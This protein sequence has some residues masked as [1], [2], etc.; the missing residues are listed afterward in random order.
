MLSGWEWIVIALAIVAILV[1]GP[2][3]IPELAKG[4]GRARGE[5]E[6]ASREYSVGTSKSEK[7][8]EASDDNMLIVV[9]KGMGIDTEGKTKDKIFQEILGNLKASKASS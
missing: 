8:N 1:W 4:L 6:K 7:A 2:T 3:K 9:A 5:F